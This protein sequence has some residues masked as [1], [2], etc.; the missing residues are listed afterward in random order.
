MAH[1][2]KP[3]FEPGFLYVVYNWYIIFLTKAFPASFYNKRSKK[4]TNGRRLRLSLIANIEMMWRVANIF[5]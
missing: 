4:K 2:K 5:F 1:N 3:G